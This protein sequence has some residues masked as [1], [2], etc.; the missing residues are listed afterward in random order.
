[1]KTLILT[2]SKD[3]T[4]DL[5]IYH[6]GNEKV[7]RL[8]FDLWYTYSFRFDS[9]GF[10]IESLHHSISLNNIKKLYWRKPFLYDIKVEDE[11]IAKHINSEIKYCFKEIFTLCARRNKAILINPFSL[12]KYGKMNQ[13]S[14]ASAYFKTPN[15]STTW[16]SP[17][18]LIGNIVVKSLSS[19]IIDKTKAIYTTEINQSDLDNKYPWFIQNTIIADFDITVVYIDG[20]IFSYKLDRSL[21]DSIDWRTEQ[22]NQKLS[23]IPYTL[24]KEDHCKIKN[25]MK[26]F[27]LIFGRLDFLLQNG[28]LVFLEINPNGQYAWL[29]SDRTNGLLD[30]ILN[31][32]SP[33]TDITCIT[34]L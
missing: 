16:N 12:D 14:I 4:T 13:L 8:N 23:W 33:Q 18:K 32:I 27:G 30:H 19:A 3:A 22:E 7:F 34:K 28:E 17:S 11:R 9:N 1:L 31:I 5:L 26:D 10:E 15:W 24:S 25:L 2:N 21:F 6:L 20:I 29:D